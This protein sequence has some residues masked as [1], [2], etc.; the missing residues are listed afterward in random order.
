[1]PSISV[2]CV[3]R[4]EA[5]VGES[6]VWCPRQKVLYWFDITGQ[7]IHRFCPSTSTNDTF[8][9]PEPVTALAIRAKGGLALS[10]KKKFAL[11]DVE[12]QALT[13]LS[14]P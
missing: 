1:M 7:K 11:F 3:V 8:H 12:S 10:L 6:P 4:E 5:I 2:D 13:Y 14:D 9:L